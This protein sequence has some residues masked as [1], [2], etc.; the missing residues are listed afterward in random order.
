MGGGQKTDSPMR[1]PF[2]WF[3]RACFMVLGG[4]IALNLAVVFLRPVLPWVVCAVAVAAVVW[5]VVAI[6]RWRRSRW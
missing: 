3:L 4:A 6:A 1:N 2:V 5:I